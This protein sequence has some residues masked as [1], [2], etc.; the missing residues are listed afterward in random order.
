MKKTLEEMSSNI[1]LAPTWDVS[2]LS[3][4]FHYQTNTYNLKNL[5]IDRSR[6]INAQDEQLLTIQ[7]NHFLSTIGNKFV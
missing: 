4:V 7:G 5:S 2:Y 1:I 3:T 6:S